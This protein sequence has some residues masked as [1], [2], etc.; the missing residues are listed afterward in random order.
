M[1]GGEVWRKRAAGPGLKSRRKAED[2]SLIIKGPEFRDREGWDTPMGLLQGGNER[3]GKA[4]NGPRR[5]GI[6]VM[7]GTW[8][9]WAVE[10]RA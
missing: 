2:G 9:W 6:A 10:E 4:G 5:D 8:T 1:C 7:L 3:Q